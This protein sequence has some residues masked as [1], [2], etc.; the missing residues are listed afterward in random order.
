M[1]TK[2][3]TNEADNSLLKKFEGTFKYLTDI[4]FFDALVGYFRASG[5]FAIRPFLEN[6]PHIRILVGIN[7][8]KIVAKYHSQGLLFKCDHAMAVEDL[9]K[10]LKD[11]IQNAKYSKDVEDGIRQFISDVINGKLEVKAHPHR[12]LH[13]KIYIFRPQEFN[14]HSTG[15]VITGSSNLTDAGIGIREICNYEFNVSLRDYDDVKFATEEFEKLWA[16]GVS[17]LP[18]EAEKLKKET[19]INDKFSPFEVY[20]KFLIEYFGKSVDFDPNSITDLPDRFVRLSYQID[21]VEQGFEMLRKHNGFFLADVV[22]TGKTVVGTLLAKKF[23]FHNDFPS[24]I[25]TILVITPPAIKQNW[26]ETFESFEMKNYDIVTNGSLH[27]IKRPEKYDLIL[28]DEAHKFRNDTA[29]AYNELQKLCKTPT[30]R[31]L[32]DGTMALKKV[33]LISATPLNNRPADIRN[34]VLLFQDGKR[35]TLPIS[36][37]TSFFSHAIEEYKKAQQL[38][39]DEA[40]IAVAHI[41][42]NI[43]EKVI[44]PLTIRRTRTDLKEN[45]EYSADL[46]KQGIQ[47]PEVV[48]PKMILYKLEPELENLYDKTI[49]IITDE[50]NGLT[51]FRYQALKY[52]VPELKRKYLN[53]ELASRQLAYIMKTLLVKRMDSSFHAFKGSMRRFYMATGAM[54]QMFE[55]GRIYIAPNLNVTEFIVEDREDELINRINSLKDID[56]SITICSPDDFQPQFLQGLKKDYKILG[57]LIEEW[58]GVNDDPK[59]DRFFADLQDGIMDKKINPQQKLVVFSESKETSDYLFDKLT[60]KGRDDVITVHAG[61]IKNK[62]PIIQANFDANYTTEGQKDDYRIVITTEVLAEGVNLHR[63]N[64]IVNYDTPWN[65]TRL[66]QRMGRIN[67]IGSVSDKIYIYNFYPTAKVDDD[68]ELRKKAI[69]KLQAFHSAL[70]EDSQIY[71]TEEEVS[72]FGIFEKNLDESKDERLAYLMELRRFK[73]ENPKEFLRIKNLPLR[74]RVGRKNRILDGCTITYIKNNKRDAFSYIDKENE[75][76][77]LTFIEAAKE[78][79]A[80]ADEVGIDLHANHHQH[81]ETAITSFNEQVES[82]LKVESIVDVTLSPQD[83]SSLSFLA[84][85]LNMAEVSEDQKLLIKA[86]QEAIRVHKYNQLPKK[87]NRLAKAVRK[88]P[89]RIDVMIDK[90]MEILLDFP[91]QI[92]DDPNDLPEIV[93]RI[94][95]QDIPEIIISESFQK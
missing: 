68:I 43:R 74:A 9:N 67:R 38:P 51:Y 53:A 69:T 95:S 3:F 12:K 90:L 52:L 78:F 32:K 1:P 8:D 13:A 33:V 50:D 66:M 62:M 56:P 89:M 41:Y 88:T 85:F 72:T 21:A 36:N 86:S 35:S 54:I 5:Y 34:L 57:D 70:G 84:A 16:E 64:S 63:S 87:I 25:S 61:N 92:K 26:K 73:K 83:K 23:F 22:G 37:L 75:L 55:S 59:F 6:V 7:V 17:I 94:I 46:E 18:V 39:I 71:S 28:V 24:H 15:E 76:A 80:Y 42:E 44:K 2:F 19:Y 49:S 29:E 93:T 65:S 81:I 91:L 31:R 20:M 58:E 4:A 27:K 48:P 77:E 40:R 60:K 79:K 47:F 45:E 14:E 11:D 10:S 30:T 82:D